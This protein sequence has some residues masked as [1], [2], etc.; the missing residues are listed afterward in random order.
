MWI[1]EPNRPSSLTLLSDP[2]NDDII[3]H[4]FSQKSFN[5]HLGAENLKSDFYTFHRKL[6]IDSDYFIYYSYLLYFQYSTC[7]VWWESK[8]RI[9]YNVHGHVVI[10]I[11]THF[12]YRTNEQQRLIGCSNNCLYRNRQYK[13][14]P[15][16]HLLQ[17]S[18]QPPQVLERS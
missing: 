8:S 12:Y 6:K 7:M 11:T 15:S 14:F 3:M 16:A 18:S 10:D 5:P 2:R 9:L 4:T 13:L 17:S 1:L